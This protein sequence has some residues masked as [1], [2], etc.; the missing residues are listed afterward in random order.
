MRKEMYSEL[1]APFLQ[2][3]RRFPMIYVIDTTLITYSSVVGF[4]VGTLY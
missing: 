1:V 3:E 2:E 4:H